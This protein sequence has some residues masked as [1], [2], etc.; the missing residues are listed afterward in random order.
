GRCEGRHTRRKRIG[1]VAALQPAQLL[2]QRAV[3]G[4]VA[5]VQARYVEARRVRRRKFRFDLVEAHRC[6]I[7]DPSIGRTMAEQ[8]ARHERAGIKT[9][10]AARDQIASAYGDEIGSTGTGADEMYCHSASL[11]SARAQVAGPIAIREAISLAAAPAAASAA[12]SA[13]EGT[14]VSAMTRWEGVSPR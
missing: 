6:G 13:T 4:E 5:R 14:P 8:L 1:N 9:N 2:G 11:A 3:N 10:R 7:D 12:A